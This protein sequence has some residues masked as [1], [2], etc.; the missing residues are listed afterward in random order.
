MN[1]KLQTQEYDQPVGQS[2]ETVEQSENG[3]AKFLTTLRGICEATKIPVFLMQ[4]ILTNLPKKLFNGDAQAVEGDWKWPVRK[5]ID[6]ISENLSTPDHKLQPGG[7]YEVQG[8]LVTTVRK[9][10]VFVTGQDF[11]RLSAIAAELIIHNALSALLKVNLHDCYSW[12]V[13]TESALLHPEKDTYDVIHSSTPG[14]FLKGS[15][16]TL[17]YDQAVRKHDAYGFIQAFIQKRIVAIADIE[18]IP[19][20]YPWHTKHI[21]SK[22][23]AGR[24]GENKTTIL[25]TTCK[26]SELGQK[27]GKREVYFLANPIWTAVIGVGGEEDRRGEIGGAERQ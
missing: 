11:L 15:D 13:A 26:P 19:D 14:L 10:I 8:H 18:E 21:I 6:Y 5:Y 27:L 2:S 22:L 25:T 20:N 4:Y 9:P 24:I 17:L 23:I 12:I 16:L 1:V 3:A 7:M